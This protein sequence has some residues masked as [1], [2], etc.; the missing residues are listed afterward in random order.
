MEQQWWS[1]GNKSDWQ[2]STFFIGMNFSIEQWINWIKIVAKCLST[3][4]GVEI[5]RRWGSRALK[6]WI[7]NGQAYL[8]KSYFFFFSCQFTNTWRFSI[9]NPLISFSFFSQ[10]VVR[11]WCEDYPGEWWDSGY[12]RSLSFSPV[13]VSKINKNVLD[14]W[15]GCNSPLF[16][17][18]KTSQQ[19]LTNV[20]T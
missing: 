18:T 6:A 19:P 7:Q 20:G 15:I 2:N 8:Y 14:W 13:P 16:K 1:C 3:I 11:W 4:T 17:L 5:R 9:S 12:F 10:V